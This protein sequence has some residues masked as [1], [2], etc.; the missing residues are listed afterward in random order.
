LIRQKDTSKNEIN[1]RWPKHGSTGKQTLLLQDFLS[2][3]LKNSI[4]LIRA[5]T[6]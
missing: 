1:W 3:A 2:G 5:K 6:N 4:V